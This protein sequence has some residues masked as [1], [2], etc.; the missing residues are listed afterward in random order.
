MARRPF[1]LAGIQA[2]AIGVERGL[3]DSVI[4]SVF[5]CFFCK[6]NI[7]IGLHLD[8]TI[9]VDSHFILSII[10]GY[11]GH[12]LPSCRI[13]AIIFEGLELP[14]WKGLPALIIGL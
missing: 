11:I 5:Y 7:T 4:S 9:K 13:Y 3:P 8:L 6:R 10:V 2:R 14:G 12:K 1:C